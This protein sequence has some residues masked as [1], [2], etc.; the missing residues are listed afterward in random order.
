M[1]VSRLLLR[2]GADHG[3]STRL[4]PPLV[5]CIALLGASQ[6]DAAIEAQADFDED[7]D[8]IVVRSRTAMCLLLQY[9]E[10]GV[11]ARD[12]P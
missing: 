3:A 1:L 5:N 9:G 11:T 6:P 4:Q 2:E 8:N 7:P 10:L 12:S